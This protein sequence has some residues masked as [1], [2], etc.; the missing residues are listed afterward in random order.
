[1]VNHPNRKAATIE[2]LRGYLVPIQKKI[3]QGEFANVS[4]INSEYL[5]LEAN[6]ESR[7]IYVTVQKGGGVPMYV[8]QGLAERFMVKYL[9]PRNRTESEVIGFYEGDLP[10]PN[11]NKMYQEYVLGQAR[12]AQEILESAPADEV[13]SDDIKSQVRAVLDPYL[14]SPESQILWETVSRQ[15]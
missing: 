4:K 14:D 3:K 12:A 10:K 5:V 11:F 1:M 7:L 2:T 15:Q 8:A 13:V 9:F 6:W